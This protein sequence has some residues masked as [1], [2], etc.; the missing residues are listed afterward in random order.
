LF[1]FACLGD[2]LLSLSHFVGLFGGLYAACVVRGKKSVYLQVVGDRGL[3]SGVNLNALGSWCE[4]QP[5]PQKWKI[6]RCI[7]ITA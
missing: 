2:F 7:E 6:S 4:S 1:P 5:Q 3:N